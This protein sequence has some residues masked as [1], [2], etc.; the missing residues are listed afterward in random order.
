MLKELS[1]KANLND[2]KKTF[3]EVASNLESRT[4]V[5]D[6]RRITESKVDKSELQF[7]L[8]GRS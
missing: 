3:T 1:L 5:S 6:V 2:I 4:T 8:Q 7:L